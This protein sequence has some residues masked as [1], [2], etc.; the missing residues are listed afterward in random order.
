MSNR[1]P[2]PDRRLALMQL[3]DSFFRQVFLLYLMV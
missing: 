3:S 2:V 1:L